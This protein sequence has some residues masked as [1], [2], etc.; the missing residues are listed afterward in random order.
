MHL[1]A[2]ADIVDLGCGTGNI[3]Q[4]IAQNWPDARTTGIDTSQ[5][6]LERAEA[7]TEGVEYALGDIG[8]FADEEDGPS[9]DLIFSN[10]ALHWLP[11]HGQ[12][13]PKLLARLRPGGTL[14]V[15][16]PLSW[17]Q[18]YARELRAILEENEL[19]SEELRER[20]G[21][22]P[23]ERSAWYWKLL[24]EQTA[25]IDLWETEYQQQLQGP[26]PIV[27]WTRGTALRPVLDE[28][29]DDAQE[30][31]LELY[32]EAVAPLYRRRGDTTLFPFR[33]LFLVAKAQD[34]SPDS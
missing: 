14:A 26:D 22:R 19:G 25:E 34:P 7:E 33:R 23:V 13:F 24:F 2:P 11:D 16:M 15:Q 5:S 6:M 29:D 10:A 18:P 4:L 27:E 31:F 28:L 12:L 30:R 9:Y 8:G 3:T 21:R 32:R 20:M 1:D 17:D